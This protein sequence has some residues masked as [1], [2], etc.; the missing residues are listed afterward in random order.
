MKLKLKNV[1]LSFADLYTAVSKFDGDP[2]FSAMFIIDKNT[3]EG[4][5]NLTEFKKIVRD[6]EKEK[7]GGK[8]LPIDKLP[9]QD[10]NDKEYTGWADMII[11][12]SAN[13][14]RPVIVGR[15]RQ[16]VAEGDPDAPYSGCYVNA[17]L[18][19]WAMDNQYGQRIIC[20]LDAIQFAK[21]GEPFVASN[22]NIESDFDELDVTE[23]SSSVFDL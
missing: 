15:K 21:D 9:I 11:M 17:I 13:K 3:E 23:V 10:G 2:K 8:E 22:V 16:P 5:A 7:L 1:R 20:S 6:L 12:S 14:K 4:K 18:D 19:V